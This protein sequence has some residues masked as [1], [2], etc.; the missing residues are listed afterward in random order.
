MSMKVYKSVQDAYINSLFDIKE[1]GRFISSVTDSSSIGNY[2]GKKKRD[3]LE[4]PGYSFV[5]SNPK[6]RLIYS[7]SRKLSFG[8]N[9]ANLI[10]LLSGRNDVGTISFYNKKGN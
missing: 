10:W 8:F 4:L 3:F 2:F 7:K 1:N 5:L 6:D 9:I